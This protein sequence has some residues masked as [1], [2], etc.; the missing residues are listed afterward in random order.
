M[1]PKLEGK[2][3]PKWGT[4]LAPLTGSHSCP[5]KSKKTRLTLM[6]GGYNDIGGAHSWWKTHALCAHVHP[7][8]YVSPPSVLQ[9]PTA[10]LC[11][12][13]QMICALNGQA[14]QAGSQA[15][16]QQQTALLSGQAG[17][18]TAAAHSGT[19]ARHMEQT[20]AL[21]PEGSCLQIKDSGSEFSTFLDHWQ[22]SWSFIPHPV[23][24]RPNLKPSQ[25]RAV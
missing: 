10:S 22:P 5:S 3:V 20:G 19:V 21:P 9:D 2:L 23:H 18:H 11:S 1:L 6:V 17:Q 12:G 13:H 24:S 16:S 4:Y 7:Q 15:Q 8:A 25:G 14:I